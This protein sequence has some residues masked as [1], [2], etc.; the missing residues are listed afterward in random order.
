MFLFFARANVETHHDNKATKG[1]KWGGN[2]SAQ[3]C[4]KANSDNWNGI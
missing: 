3:E 2:T 4:A 1:L